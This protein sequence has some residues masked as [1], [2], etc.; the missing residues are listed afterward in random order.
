MK[1]NGYREHYCGEGAFG[2]MFDA[3]L[4]LV[5]TVDILVGSIPGG[6]SILILR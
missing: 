4:I 1:L 5:D 2:N 3:F 6:Q